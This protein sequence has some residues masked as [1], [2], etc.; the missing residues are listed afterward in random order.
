VDARG[1]RLIVN[2]RGDAIATGA[3][4]LPLDRIAA[5]GAVLADPRWLAG[6]TRAFEAAREAGVP[7]VLDADV[8]PTGSLATLV[9]LA[10]HVVF[11]EPG[12][13]I[14]ADGRDELAA[15]RAALDAGAKVAGVTRGAK[16]VE[17]IECG[18]PHALRRV[19]APRVEARDT[20]GAGDVFHGAYALGLAEGRDVAGAASF[21]CAA[22]SLKCMRAGARAGSPS[23]AEVE[24]LLRGA[25]R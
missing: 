17:W 1:E 23:R 10:D 11:S 9:P 22:A 16:G 13:A 18:S 21:A 15:L 19:P 6:A 3:D 12:L 25:P 7:C 24:R 14:Y 5:A 8:A 4:W 20:T 2:H